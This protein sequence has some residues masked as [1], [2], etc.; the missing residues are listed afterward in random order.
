M[1]LKRTLAHRHV[2]RFYLARFISSF[3]NGMGPIALAFGILHLKNGSASEL[4][5]VLGSS[6]VAF[7]CVLPFGVVLAD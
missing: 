4:G 2:K 5:L 1:S 6:T 7:L 3:G